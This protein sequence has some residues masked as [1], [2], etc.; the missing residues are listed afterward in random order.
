M[1]LVSRWS[2]A[3]HPAG[4]H[5][6][7]H[8]GPFLAAHPSLSQDGFHR[9]GFWEVGRTYDGLAPPPTFG[10]SGILLVGS[11]LLILCSLLGPLGVREFMHVAIIVP[12]QGRQF[13]STVF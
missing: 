7:S 6:W 10:S 13:R 2:L 9:E 4:A 3:N 8:S 5:I 1:G 12:D 11:S